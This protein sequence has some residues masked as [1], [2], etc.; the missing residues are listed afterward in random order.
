MHVIRMQHPAK[1]RK[2]PPVA[3]G[4]QRSEGSHRGLAGRLQSKH[5][6]ERAV[7]GNAD[8]DVR[9]GS[10]DELGIFAVGLLRGAEGV[11][12]VRRR[13]RWGAARGV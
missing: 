3:H 13:H 10:R 4:T 2:D 6:C 5:P 8:D 7:L 11:G 1:Y 12:D 9:G